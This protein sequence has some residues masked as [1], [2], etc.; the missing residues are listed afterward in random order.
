M[1]HLSAFEVEKGDGSRLMATCNMVAGVVNSKG[2][3]LVG[4]AVLAG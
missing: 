3:V 4:E 1:R 2:A